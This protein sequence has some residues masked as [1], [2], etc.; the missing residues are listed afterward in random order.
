MAPSKAAAARHSAPA[1]ETR[2]KLLTAASAVFAERGFHAA[3]VREICSRANVNVALVNYHFGDKLELYTE[4]LRWAVKDPERLQ[5]LHDLLAQ[6]EEPEVLLRK[7]IGL[8]LD[9][10]IKRRQRGPLH[11]RL[12]LHELARPTPAIARVVDESVKPL[13]DRLCVLLGQFLNLPPDDAK[14]R[15]CAQ[16]IIGQ[17][18]HY[19]HHS[20]VI[21]RLWPELKM[22]PE[23]QEVVANHVAD[24]SLSYLRSLRN[25]QDSVRSTKTSRRKAL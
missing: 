18:I 16:S 9:T 7:M 10:M 13:H 24:F 20:P 2:L 6:N 17:L 3:T 5:Q 23:Q 8:M 4:V 25:E 21:A 14:T 11:M 15:L 12:M 1:D 22:T 19:A